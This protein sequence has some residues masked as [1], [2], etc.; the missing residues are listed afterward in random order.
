MGRRPLSQRKMHLRFGHSFGA[1]CLRSVP[2]EQLAEELPETT[3]ISCIRRKMAGQQRVLEGG[4]EDCRFARKQM[5]ALMG[6]ML[7]EVDRMRALTDRV[8]EI[9]GF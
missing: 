3:C 8:K 6:V 1:W 2:R 9:K 4:R 5:E 7:I